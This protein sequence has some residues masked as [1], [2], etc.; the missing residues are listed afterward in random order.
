MFK[1]TKI[2]ATIGPASSE[3]TTLNALME[4]G[5]SIF[6]LNFSH[7]DL[8]NKAL[9]IKR[10]RSVSRQRQQVVA[11]LGDLQGPKIRVGLLKDGA[12]TL[13]P[14]AEVIITSRDLLGEDN[15]IPTFYKNL[16]LD[17]Q[18]GDLILLDDGLMELELLDIQGQDVRCQV[19]FGG[20]LKN[21]KGINLPGVAVSAPSLTEKD[22]QDLQFC[23]E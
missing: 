18:P 16:P 11:I 17:V 23:I 6:R 21:R 15:L 3:E 2:V 10:I 20:L 9:L 1:H 14:G 19:K 7:G 13:T 8:E 22:Q 4:A 12:M 5:A